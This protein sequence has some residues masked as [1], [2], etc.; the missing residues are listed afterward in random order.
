MIDFRELIV[1]LQI[2]AVATRIEEEYAEA[3]EIAQGLY[4]PDQGFITPRPSSA[5]ESLEAWNR[6]LRRVRA[7]GPR[8]LAT[9]VNAA[10]GDVNWGGQS[11]KLDELIDEQGLLR[12]A[13]QMARDYYVGGVAA[14]YAYQ[15][16]KSP[17]RIG[18]ITGYIEPYTSPMD[19]DVVTGLYQAKQVITQSGTRY[20][21]RV[22]DLEDGQV[23]EWREL[24][25][26]TDL[27]KPPDRVLE[28]LTPRFA[29]YDLTPEG[30]AW[31]PFY[32]AIPLFRDLL[33]TELYLA[34]VEE[35]TAYPIPRFGADTE[36]Q[37]IAPGLPVQGEFEWVTPGS[38]AELREQR[39]VK[40]ERL[41]D[42]MALPGGFLGNDSPSGEAL[43]EANIRFYQ[44]A[45]ATAKALSTLLTDLVADLAKIVGAEPVEVVVLP[46]RDYIREQVVSNAVLLYEKGLIPLAVAAREV[47]PFV[48]TWSDEELN[49]WLEANKDVV[50]PGDV[51]RLLGGGA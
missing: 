25:N 37:Q 19:A 29:F 44:E 51:A 3:W 27:A 24:F 13:R 2:H 42:A 17:P 30:L 4:E 45:Q 43:R 35:L 22:W 28:G 47:Q 11:K 8:V 18:R 32:W 14:G 1:R 36:P 15:P 5:P 9:L 6:A 34:R 49:Q 48:P 39:S 16:E 41:R 50:T 38:L 26:P 31:S 7:H 23:R 33:A 21:V 10:V 46:N 20:W 40:L 12:L